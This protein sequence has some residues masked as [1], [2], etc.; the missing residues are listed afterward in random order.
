MFK[1][2]KYLVLV[3]SIAAMTG[4]GSEKKATVKE[5]KGLASLSQTEI[6]IGGTPREI[7][8]TREGY[9]DLGT[10]ATPEEIAGWDIDIRPDGTGLPP[11][12]GSALDGEDLYQA[13]CASCHGVFGEGSGRWPKLAGG[14]GTLNKDRPEKTVGSYWPYASTLWDYIHRAMPFTQPQS[15]SDDEVY[16]L[17]AYV[18]YMNDIIDEELV[19]NAQN[20][21][22]VEMPNKD[23]FFIDPRPD[24][25]NTLCMSNCREADSI[26]ITWDASDLGVTPV[27][28]LNQSDDGADAG[29]NITV[30]VENQA[31]AKVYNTACGVCHNN[32][33]AGAPI[34]AD[35]L[36]DWQKRAAQGI[37]VVVEHAINGYSG[38]KGMMPA[39]GGQMHLSD[40]EVKAAVKHMLTTAGVN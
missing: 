16:A 25:P 39:K 30:N 38:A 33:V 17:T 14:F 1:S 15:L 10:P 5:D 21:A 36:K 24:S 28:H 34:L 31:G 13:K 12:S 6:R 8:T 27:A 35:N 23:G 20:L 11:G 4:C 19:L 22:S 9:Y 26:K 29:A 32:G 3:L 2:T 18:L 40:E 7:D 37:D